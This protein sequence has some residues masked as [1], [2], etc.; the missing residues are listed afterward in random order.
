MQSSIESR[1]R[2]SAVSS[3]IDTAVKKAASILVNDSVASSRNT[4]NKGSLKNAIGDLLNQ[5]PRD[6]Q[7]EILKEAVSQ[8]A[9]S[10]GGVTAT[11]SSRSSSE[12]KKKKP[13]RGGMF[14]MSFSDYDDDDSD[15]EL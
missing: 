15:F 5:F 1:T 11:K 7:I 12:K 8:M 9:M 14:G 13:Q 2:L 4:S 3:E 6:I 10:L